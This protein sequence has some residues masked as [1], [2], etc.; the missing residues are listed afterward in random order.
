MTNFDFVITVDRT[1]MSNHHGREFIGFLT[2]SPPVGMP[3]RIWMWIAAPK[4]KVDKLGRPVEAPYGLRKIEAALQNAGFRAAIIDPDY[5]HLHLPKAKALLIGHHDFFAF[6]APSNTWWAVTKKEP[7]NRR[8]FIRLMES[9]PIREFKRRGGKIIVGGPA[10]WQW[11]HVEDLWERWGVDTVVEGEGEKIIVELAQKIIDGEPLPKYVYV[12]PRDA[13]TVEE[14]PCIKG[15]S[16][17]GLVE[18]MRGCPRGCRFCSVTVRPLRYIPIEKVIDEIRVNKRF[19]V[20]HVLLHSEDILLY[21]ADGV[22]PR[23]EP[24][25]KLHEAI[26]REKPESFA[27]SHL[28][29]AS[30]VYSERNYKLVSKLSEMILSRTNQKF[31]G[32]QVGIETGSPRL[33]KAIMPGKPA[34]YKPDEWPDLV[35]EAFAI[36][37]DNKIFPAA[38]IILNAPG[39]TED[40]VIKTIELM[41]RLKD[42]PSLIVPLYFVPMGV[43]KNRKEMLNFRVKPVHAEAMWKCLEH[44]LRWAPKLADMYL[45]NN[46]IM[47]L[48]IKAFIK[49]VEYKKRSLE[50]KL[51]EIFKKLAETEYVHTPTTQ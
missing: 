5:L 12:S 2:T 36:M 1:L 43:L 26:F 30:V 49:F 46:P 31:I 13:P 7:V 47:K 21:G 28:S 9:K 14:I 4:P 23:E 38:T 6:C 42:Y 16:V 40:D 50:K 18:I 24:V 25:L 11:L 51:K 20:S 10:A 44:S 29:V 22:L 19:G 27:W 33:V 37:T 45:A 35:E 41:D 8:Y 17:N 15:A 48:A 3:E 32:V 39:E 34:P